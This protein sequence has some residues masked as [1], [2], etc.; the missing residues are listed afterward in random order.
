MSASCS[1]WDRGRC[2]ST[3]PPCGWGTRRCRIMTMWRWRSAKATPATQRSPSCPAR[4]RSCRR[5]PAC[6]PE[7]C[8]NRTDGSSVSSIR[9][10]TNCQWISAI[11][12]ASG[13]GRTAA[14][15]SLTPQASP[16]AGGRLTGRAIGGR[17]PAAPW[18]TSIGSQRKMNERS[19]FPTAWRFRVAAIRCVPCGWSIT[20]AITSMRTVSS[21][22]PPARR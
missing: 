14:S 13:V 6:R 1:T 19:A 17:S 11:R 12:R 20:R 21:G 15:A 16:W 8:G 7:R 9:M 3:K 10:P 2:P 4:W 18:P 22:L 5:V